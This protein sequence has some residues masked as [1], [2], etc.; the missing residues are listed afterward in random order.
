MHRAGQVVGFEDKGELNGPESSTGAT[1]TVGAGLLEKLL[2]ERMN[3]H[4]HNV[5]GLLAV[6]L[7]A[8]KDIWAALP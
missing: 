4:L 7:S 6:A 1:G 2:A 3:E 8:P 5:F